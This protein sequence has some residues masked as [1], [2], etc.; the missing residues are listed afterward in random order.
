LTQEF[1]TFFKSAQNSASFDTICAQF[2]RNF[3][4]TL[5]QG[6]CYFLAVK[7][8][9]KIETVQY[10]KKSFLIVGQSWNLFDTSSSSSE[11]SSFSISVS[12]WSRV[13]S[14]ANRRI[15]PLCYFEAYKSTA[16]PLASPYASRSRSNFSNISS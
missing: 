3:L 15:Q 16:L 10:L 5:I 2:R 8:S 14:S 9:N 11:R 4:S 13:I 1:Y 12:N 6:R 7:S